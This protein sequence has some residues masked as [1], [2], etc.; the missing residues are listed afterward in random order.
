[1]NPN[2]NA[3]QFFHGTTANIPVGSAVRPPGSPE[4]SNFEQLYEEKG[5]EWRSQHV[6]STPTEDTAWMWASIAGNR[7]LHR[8]DVQSR[9]R[10]YE[11]KPTGKP[12]EAVPPEIHQTENEII[13]Q[14]A[15]SKREVWTPPPSAARHVSSNW[16]PVGKA[17]RV[18]GMQGTL[19]PQDWRGSYADPA[20]SPER[21]QFKE[22][23]RPTEPPLGARLPPERTRMA[24]QRRLLPA[25]SRKTQEDRLEPILTRTQEFRRK[26]ELSERTQNPEYIE[27]HRRNVRSRRAFRKPGEL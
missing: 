7:Q 8:P 20:D 24:G 1:M 27:Q 23:S 17:G 25:A 26:Y 14:R 5:Q 18:V 15:L 21:A 10:V 19:P 9:P 11:V 6:F 22:R 16:T 3:A 13:S 4:Q 12:D 2:V